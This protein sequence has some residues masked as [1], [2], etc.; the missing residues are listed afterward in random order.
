MRTGSLNRTP[1]YLLLGALACLPLTACATQETPLGTTQW[2]V[3]EITTDA[4][5]PSLIPDNQQ[6]RAFLVFGD[7]DFTGA[8]GCI[9]FRGHVEWLENKT[10]LRFRDV[11]TDTREDAPCLPGDEDNADRMKQVLADHDLDI[12]RPNDTTLRLELRGGDQPAWQTKPALEFI[13]GPEKE[14]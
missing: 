3:T 14:R 12:V 7:K 13:S 1:R 10:V 4:T 11:S 8:S 5:R 2:Q 9:S 6:G